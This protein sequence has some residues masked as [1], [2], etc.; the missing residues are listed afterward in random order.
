MLK[1]TFEECKSHNSKDKRR[2]AVPRW[3][4]R[5]AIAAKILGDG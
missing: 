3:I 5:V 2:I 4:A 1:P